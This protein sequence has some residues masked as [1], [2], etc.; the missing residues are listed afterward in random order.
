MVDDAVDEG[1]GARGVGE[2]VG[3]FSYLRD[4]PWKSRSAFRAS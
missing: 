1:D 2:E 4:T 3:F